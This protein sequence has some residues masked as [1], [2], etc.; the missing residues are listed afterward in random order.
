MPD[1]NEREILQSVGGHITTFS[2]NLKL[3]QEF[4]NNER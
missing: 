1:V 2:N 4:V 3:A